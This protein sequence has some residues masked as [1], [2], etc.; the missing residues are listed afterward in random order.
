MIDGKKHEVLQVPGLLLSEACRKMEQAGRGGGQ[1]ATGW[2]QGGIHPTELGQY[3]Y[4]CL[5][6]TFISGKDPHQIAFKTGVEEKDAKWI[7]DN[8]WLLYNKHPKDKGRP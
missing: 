6:Y 3:A 5:I 8:V 2:E 1:R 4:G 7:W